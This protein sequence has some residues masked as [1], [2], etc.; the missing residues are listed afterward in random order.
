MAWQ[1]Q[2]HPVV[3]KSGNMKVA[4]AHAVLACERQ[5]AN[6]TGKTASQVTQVTLRLRKQGQHGADGQPN[7]L[8]TATK[9]VAI[10]LMD[11]VQHMPV[12]I[13]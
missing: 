12:W 1:F 13:R 7:I 8:Y 9:N 10:K 3:A 4:F 5:C 6:S 11:I 2:A